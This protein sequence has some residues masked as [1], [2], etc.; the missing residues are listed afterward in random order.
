MTRAARFNHHKGLHFTGRCGWQL[1]MMAAAL[2]FNRGRYFYADCVKLVTGRSPCITWRL[3]Q[4]KARK[5]DS[6]KKSKP[7][8]LNFCASAK[9]QKPKTPR[10]ASNGDADYG[11]NPR[12]PDVAEEVPCFHSINIHT[13]IA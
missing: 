10:A 5:R 6:R 8:K 2:S 9:T 13:S 4:R 12:Y 7:R 1:R 3:A 11:S